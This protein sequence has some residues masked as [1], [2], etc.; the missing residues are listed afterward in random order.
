MEAMTRDSS[1]EEPMDEVMYD[2]FAGKGVITEESP[3][4]EEAE[5]LSENGISADEV[6]VEGDL[7]TF[8]TAEFAGYEI[9]AETPGFDA[10]LI[11]ELGPDMLVSSTTNGSEA[12]ADAL[13]EGMNAAAGN[14]TAQ[15][16]MSPDFSDNMTTLTEP[17]SGIFQHDI[18][19][20][21]SVW[22]FFGCIFVIALLFIREMYYRKK[23]I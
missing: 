2:S 12:G 22:F 19:S 15:L 18:F 8:E 10:P 7:D 1:V 4:P 5:M 11:D 6:T 17:V 23:N 13:R 21:V 9:P 3:S 16:P 14:Q 20:H